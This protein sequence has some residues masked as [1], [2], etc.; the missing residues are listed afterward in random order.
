[1]AGG[2]EEWRKL[3]L[4]IE[5]VHG[6]AVPDQLELAPPMRSAQEEFKI[7]G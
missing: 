4:P 2:F 6:V 5:P 1:L 3:G 7:R